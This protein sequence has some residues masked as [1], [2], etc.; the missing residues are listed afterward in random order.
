MGREQS[1]NRGCRPNLRVLRDA[2]SAVTC[3]LVS[4]AD[5]LFA[6]SPASASCAT[7]SGQ[8]AG[9]VSCATNGSLVVMV[10]RMAVQASF[11][12]GNLHILRSL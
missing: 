3:L 8:V 1:I 4:A 10:M 2:S 11:F 6:F 9:L 12:Y 7:A 5:D